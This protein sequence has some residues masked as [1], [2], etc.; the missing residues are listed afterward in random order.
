MLFNENSVSHQS[1]RSMHFPYS[2]S[3]S[4][5]S[6]WLHAVIWS[7]ILPLQMVI[8]SVC[9]RVYH[10][11]CLL[12]HEFPRTWLCPE[13][14]DLTVAECLVYRPPQWSQITKEQLKS[15]LLF[16]VNRLARQQWVS[17]QWFLYLSMF[18]FSELLT[19]ESHSCWHGHVLSVS[20]VSVHRRVGAILIS[21]TTD[22]KS[23]HC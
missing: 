12:T 5:L 3:F 20:D 21:T 8:C 23:P 14:Q 7:W 10:P 19:L 6:S 11:D 16:L 4:K 13:C 15:M 1:L 17:I 22:W 18:D 2:T 9:P